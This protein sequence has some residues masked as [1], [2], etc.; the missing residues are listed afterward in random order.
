VFVGSKKAAALPQP[1]PPTASTPKEPQPLGVKPPAPAAKQAPS[2]AHKPAPAAAKAPTPA[3]KAPSPP[4]TA[5]PSPSGTPKA[6]KHEDPDRGEE[7][8]SF[9]F[10]SLGDMGSQDN[11]FDEQ[12]SQMR[13]ITSGQYEGLA[14]NI[15]AFYRVHDPAKLENKEAFDLILKWTFKHGVGALDKKFQEHYG[16]TLASVKVTEADREALKKQEEDEDAVID[17]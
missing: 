5:S 4:V 17:W 3:A 14:V 16:A 8:D 15:R 1:P 9:S 6:R 7:T 2:P 13:R 12:M 10:R 11:Y